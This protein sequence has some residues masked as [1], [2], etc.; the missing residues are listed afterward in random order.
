M[1]VIDEIIKEFF[2]EKKVTPLQKKCIRWAVGLDAL[3]SRVKAAENKD[4]IDWLEAVVEKLRINLAVDNVYNIPSEGPVVIIANHPTVIDGMGVIVAAAKVRRDIKIVA[5]QVLTHML[6][7]TKSLTIG[8]R[9]MQGKMGTSQ[10]REMNAHLKKG[11]VLVIFPSGR[12]AS[13]KKTGLQEAPWNPGFIHLATKNN[14]ALVPVNIQGL[15]TWRYYITARFWRPLSNLMV[16]RECLRHS[17]KTLKINFLQQVN[18]AKLD[19]DKERMGEVAASFMEHIK[20]AGQNQPGIL[21]V[22]TPVAPP[23]DKK[24]LSA[25]LES[26]TELKK[27]NDGKIVLLYRHQ[28]TE[29][30]PVLRELGRLREICFREIGAGTGQ[31]YDNDIYDKDYQHIMVWDPE[32]LEIAGAYRF[33]MAG[34]QIAKR[35]LQGLYSN[36]LFNY[37]QEFSAIASKSIEIGRGFIQKQYQKTNVLDELWK[38]IFNVALKHSEY[39]YLIGVLTIP[40]NYSDY[41]KKLMIGFYQTYLSAD[42]DACSPVEK[43]DLVD[44][45]INRLFSGD[46]FDE[47]WKKLNI[48]LRELGCDLPWPYKQAAKWYSAGGSKIL[49]FVEDKHFNSI[50]GLN[51]CEIDKLK[52]SYG[53]RYL[54]K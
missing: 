7:K 42:Q 12:L 13:L 19:V 31:D 25:A 45:D 22:I 36:E 24:L 23:L 28:G 41:A 29:Y 53:K 34:E 50:A 49:C 1:D 40:Q 5:N 33:V 16:I 35:G 6:P 8:I 39:K 54:P 38:G 17:G 15:N 11:G 44:E 48:E 43:Y 20:R 4:G 47:D 26:C 9:N 21:P 2:P 27:L 46:H 51:L 32:R 18:L 52:K 14:A 37:K 3:F 30:S 10:Y